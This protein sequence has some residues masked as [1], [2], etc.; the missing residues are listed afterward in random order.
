MP[1]RGTGAL[2]AARSSGRSAVVVV[3]AAGAG[4]GHRAVLHDPSRCSAL[5]QFDG[6]GLFEEQLIQ[7]RQSLAGRIDLEQFAGLGSQDDVVEARLVIDRRP[8]DDL[9]QF[10]HQRRNG[11]LGIR[12]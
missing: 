12:T 6:V 2:A 11:G 10:L 1:A 9:I 5:C 3:L 4:A 7:P 8:G